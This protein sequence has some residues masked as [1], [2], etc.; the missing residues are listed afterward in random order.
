M[1]ERAILI[2]STNKNNKYVFTFSMENNNKP[3]SVPW[4]NAKVLDAKDLATLPTNQPIAIQI[5]RLK[6]IVE[7]VIING[8]EYTKFKKPRSQDSQNRR[9]R[10]GSQ[11]SSTNRGQ[12]RSGV[13]YAQIRGN[14]FR[15][16]ENLEKARAPYNF[17]PLNDVVVQFPQPPSRD[18]YHS[19]RRT[20]YLAV[21]MTTLTPLFVAMVYQSGIDAPQVKEAFMA[22]LDDQPFIPGSS[23]RGVIRQ[24]LEIV[25]YAKFKMFDRE[26]R[27]F[28]RALADTT[29]LK[30][31]YQDYMQ[32][33]V[34]S[35]PKSR[36]S[37]KSEG[38]YLNYDKAE[39]KYYI[40]P[41]QRIEGTSYRAEDYQLETFCYREESDKSY[42]ISTGPMPKKKKILRMYPPDKH[43]ATIWLSNDDVQ[44]YQSDTGRNIP[45]NILESAK[46]RRYVSSKKCRNDVSF[47][48]GVPVFYQE[49]KGPRDNR[50]IFGHTPYFR[51]PYNYSIGD[52][53]PKD[54]KESGIDLVD[55]LFGV[56]HA[57]KASNGSMVSNSWATRLFFEDLT[58]SSSNYDWQLFGVCIPKILSAP[59]PTTIQHYL[60]QHDIK[61]QKQRH[62]WNTP[63]VNLRGYKLYW[64]RKTPHDKQS[65]YSW[66]EKEGVEENDRTHIKMHNVV[67]T[68]VKFSGRI[69]FENLTDVELGALLFVLQLPPGCALKLGMGKPLGL[70]SV[71]V[72]VDHIIQQDP[73][74]Y[75]CNLTHDGTWDRA[76]TD[77]VLH[78][79]KYRRIFEEYM[80]AEIY[81]QRGVEGSLPNRSLW[82]EPRLSKLRKILTWPEYHDGDN[83]AW[84]AA[85]RYLDIICETDCV[86]CSS[87]KTKGINTAINE[88]RS[89]CI[90]P[91]ID[92]VLED[93]AKRKH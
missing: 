84:N 25:A 15:P 8:K 66:L 47:P 17:V 70:G 18:R 34:S 74:R 13:G 77:V 76:E 6:G 90:L 53:V 37:P 27:L 45:I 64:H 55:A 62:N 72:Q 83:E 49:I 22:T 21:T 65:P 31:E 88:Y 68:G 93:F 85:T 57:S 73:M 67:K 79:E 75:Y 4:F 30:E 81:R 56:P 50:V 71:Q 63:G 24:L 10:H 44:D 1:N 59:K 41:A 35:Q 48:H 92:K 36:T 54:I 91:S 20:G 46:Q 32:G 80:M 78:A 19:T 52:H 43:G 11:S 29:D 26:R 58:L 14:P 51:V 39:H 9:A 33:P 87:N 12:A 3:I 7:T 40:I 42:L 60:E 28:F 16:S 2:I 86:D 61:H 69:R 89:R 38:G 23:F 5:C 82:D